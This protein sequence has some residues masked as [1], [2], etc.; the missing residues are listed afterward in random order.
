M[1]VKFFWKKS[2]KWFSPKAEKRSIWRSLLIPFL[3]IFTGLVFG[4]IF[5][6]ITNVDVYAAFGRSFTEGL[7]LG[8]EY[9]CCFVYSPFQRCHWR[10]Q[11]DRRS[12]EF[13]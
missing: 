2:K 12:L 1:L 8:L 6:V 10:P 13:R 5:N 4:A 7:A 11:I 9:S 3:A